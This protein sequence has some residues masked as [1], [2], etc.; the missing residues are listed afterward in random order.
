MN[1]PEPRETKSLEL[2]DTKS[3]YLISID[4]TSQYGVELAQNCFG[5]G[6]RREGNIVVNPIGTRPRLIPKRYRQLVGC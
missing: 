3:I 1:V 6:A 2:V 4:C 5:I